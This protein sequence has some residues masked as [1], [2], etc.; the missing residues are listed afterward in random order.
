[1]IMP[2]E[3]NSLDAK[4]SIWQMVLKLNL[5][6]SLKGQC[7]CKLGKGLVHSCLCEGVST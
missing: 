7:K 3:R 1:M 5:I 2:Q 6:L 4:V